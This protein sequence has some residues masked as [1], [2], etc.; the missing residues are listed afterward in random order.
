ME[1]SFRAPQRE[2]ARALMR[3]N[4]ES[5]FGVPHEVDEILELLPPRITLN[6]PEIILVE[7][8]SAKAGEERLTAAMIKRAET[9]ADTCGCKFG[10]HASIREGVFYRYA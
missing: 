10:Y 5:S 1:M 8:F 2:R 9:F 3:M 4:D 6:V 7:W